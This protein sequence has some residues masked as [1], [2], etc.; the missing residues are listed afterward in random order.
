MGHARR[1]RTEGLSLRSVDLN[2][3]GPI[4][5]TDDM[6]SLVSQ[7]GY[8]PSTGV[9]I[10]TRGVMIN[11]GCLD[12]GVTSANWTED[13]SGL[14]RD[15]KFADFVEAWSFMNHVAVLAETMDHHPDWC[16]SY[17]RVEITLI[18]HDKG[19]VTERDRR[20]AAAIDELL[21]S[22]TAERS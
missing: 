1:V 18:S 16:N 6:V 12:T 3:A 10:A 15:F 5:R 11:A 4:G 22:I 17:N 9:K 21:E 13:E 7:R 19:Q 8:S 14:H 2:R 20:M